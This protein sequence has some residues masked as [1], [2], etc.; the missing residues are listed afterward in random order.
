MLEMGKILIIFGGTLILLGVIFIFIPKVPYLGKLPGD[1]YIKKE[2]FNF[3]FP[4]TSCLIIS[5]I[6]SFIIWFFKKLF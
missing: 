2:N 3:Y 4:L 1:I 6:I 5:F